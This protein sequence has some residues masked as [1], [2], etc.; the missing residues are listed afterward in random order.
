[1]AGVSVSI[2][3]VLALIPQVRKEWLE[4]LGPPNELTVERHLGGFIQEEGSNRDLADVKVTVT[5]PEFSKSE[6]T[7]KG[8]HFIFRDLPARTN[9]RVRLKAEKEGYVDHVEEN[10]ELGDSNLRFAM[11]NKGSP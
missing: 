5:S 2:L 7:D 11:K 10:L 9:A 4:L 6:K 8:G 1:M 3:T